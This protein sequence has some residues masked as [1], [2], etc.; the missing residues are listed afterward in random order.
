MTAQ[1]MTEGFTSPMYCFNIQCFL[2]FTELIMYQKGQVS[3]VPLYEI[4]LC[5]GEEWPDG[6]PKEKKLIMVQVMK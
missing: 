4:Q 2:Y 6:K 1:H 3:V 5:F